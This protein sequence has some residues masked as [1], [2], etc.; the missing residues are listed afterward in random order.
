MAYTSGVISVGI[1]CCT[2]HVSDFRVVSLGRVS[3]SGLR[4][5][6]RYVSSSLAPEWIEVRVKK[7][8]SW[9]R[10]DLMLQRHFLKVLKAYWKFSP[11]SVALIDSGP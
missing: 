5:Y 9:F 2:L 3:R 6:P 7:G 1:F 11:T 4:P 8:C 10:L